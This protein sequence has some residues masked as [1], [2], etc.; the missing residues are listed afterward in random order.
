VS[1]EFCAGA[2][3]RAAGALQ[4]ADNWPT[5][6]RQLADNALGFLTKVFTYFLQAHIKAARLMGKATPT[7]D[8]GRNTSSQQK[9]KGRT[10]NNHHIRVSSDA[11]SSRQG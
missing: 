11:S 10:A 6:G 5:I 2:T 3:G 7:N 8:K 4:P 9:E 1:V